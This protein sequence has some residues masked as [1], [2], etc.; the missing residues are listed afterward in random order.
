MV[1]GCTV[2]TI[3]VIGAGGIAHPALWVLASMA[4][5][6][7]VVDDDRVD[8]TNLHRLPFARLEDI[9]AHKVEV[10]ARTIRAHG[11]AKV[12]P[13]VDRLT[14]DTARALLT[15]ADLVIDGSDNYATKFLVADACGIL[16]I[17]SVHGAAVGWIGTVLPVRPGRSACYRCLFEDIPPGDNVDCATMGVYGPVT[18]VIGALMAA[19]AIR[20]LHGNDA[21]VGSIACYDGWAQTFRAV[22]VPRR[23][24][25]PLCGTHSICTLEASRYDPPEC[26]G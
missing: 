2:P 23:S 22:R 25:C 26:A 24:D 15:G 19:D 11:R 16:G 14:P 10:I 9:G 5:H 7:R 20:M 3:V 17:P 6:I 4:V 12:E 13:V 1:Q 21:T 18:S 8:P